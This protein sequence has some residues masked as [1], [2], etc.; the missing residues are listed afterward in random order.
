M[1]FDSPPS[2]ERVC[3]LAAQVVSTAAGAALEDVLSHERGTRP[4]MRVRAL[5]MYVAHVGGRLPMTAVA[6]GF[7]RHRST[8]S[9]ACLQVEA[10]REAGTFDLKVAVLECA[11]RSAIAQEASHV[12]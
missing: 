2:P 7:D 11:L 6:R 5:A 3:F 4:V 8:V 12:A 9:H 1:M 10:R